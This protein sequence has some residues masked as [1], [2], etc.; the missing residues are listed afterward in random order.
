MYSYPL[1][2][3][4]Q[5]A[6]PEFDQM[7]AFQAAGVQFS[8]RRGQHDT[9]AKPLRGEFVTGNY[10]STFGIRSLAGRTIAPSDDQAAAPPVAMLSYRA[11][12]QQYDSDPSVVGSTFI[13]EGHPF[14]I[15]GIAPPGFF[16]ETLRSNP[17]E[18]WLPLQQEPLSNADASLPHQSISTS[19]RVIA[20]SH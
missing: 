18:L 13:V 6:A 11:W 19:L 1:F 14:T 12:Q 17:P 8:V 10:F 20:M 5:A 2:L 16:G 7:A 3:R 4:L 9:M 15:A